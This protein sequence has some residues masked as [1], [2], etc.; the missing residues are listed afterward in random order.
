[1]RVKMSLRSQIDPSSSCVFRKWDS[2]VCPR[3]RRSPSCLRLRS[4]IRCPSADCD[5]LLPGYHRRCWSPCFICYDLPQFGAIVDWMLEKKIFLVWVN[6]R[7]V[8]RVNPPE[9]SLRRGGC[10][11]KTILD[12]HFCS[13]FFFFW[14]LVDKQSPTTGQRFQLKLLFITTSII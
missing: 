6:I 1:M 14:W 11:E 5:R 8:W 13:S 2:L 4:I 7:V 9:L 12:L 10:W 3:H